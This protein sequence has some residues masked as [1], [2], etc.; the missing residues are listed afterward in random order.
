MKLTKAAR[1][2]E[3]GK[4]EITISE[5]FVHVDIFRNDQI[6]EHYKYQ[7]KDLVDKNIDRMLVS[8]GITWSD[9]KSMIKRK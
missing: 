3:G 6:I 2:V 4:T 7:A 1:E 5:G 8:S 9:F